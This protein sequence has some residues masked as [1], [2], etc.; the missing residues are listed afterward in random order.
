MFIEYLWHS[1]RPRKLFI[2]ITFPF[3]M[4]ASGHYSLAILRVTSLIHGA[5]L[6]DKLTMVRLKGHAYLFQ[7]VEDSE[8]KADMT[9]FLPVSV[10]W[11]RNDR[12]GRAV[13]NI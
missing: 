2:V 4:W 5:W 9:S 8:S 1:I 11:K 6:F 13:L 7:S 3:S 10:P 12:L